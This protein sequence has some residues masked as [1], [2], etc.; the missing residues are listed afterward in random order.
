VENAIEDLLKGEEKAEKKDDEED[1]AKELEKAQDKACKHV[2]KAE[3][4]TDGAEEPKKDWLTGPDTP[5]LNALLSTYLEQ[6]C[7]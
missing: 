4:R 3:E 6:S 1:K 2:E 7:D 5:A